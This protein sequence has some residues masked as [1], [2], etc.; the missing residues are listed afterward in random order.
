MAPR[1]SRPTEVGDHLLYSLPVEGA[2][3]R[4]S[5]FKKGAS[6]LVHA[7]AL[8]LGEL[9]SQ[10]LYLVHP[11]VEVVVDGAVGSP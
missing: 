10:R 2:A 6:H 1:P 7:V 5:A 8:Y 3:P 9:G 11:L 4:P